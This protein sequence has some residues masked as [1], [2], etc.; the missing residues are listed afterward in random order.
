MTTDFRK[1]ENESCLCNGK[2]HREIKEHLNC[3]Y[4]DSSLSVTT[5]NNRFNKFQRGLTSVFD[6][7]FNKVTRVHDLVLALRRFNMCGQ[8]R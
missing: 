3:V 8:L 6:E 5:V 1:M 2:L 7:D 4:G